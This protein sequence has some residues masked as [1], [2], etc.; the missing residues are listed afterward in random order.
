MTKRLLYLDDEQDYNLLVSY[1]EFLKNRIDRNNLST[2][3]LDLLDDIQV[4]DN[5]LMC[6]EH[7]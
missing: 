5:K 7:D 6:I 1:I 3:E 4:E 2:Y